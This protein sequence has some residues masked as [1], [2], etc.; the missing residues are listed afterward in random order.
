MA[1][2]KY[3]ATRLQARAVYA[4][5]AIAHQIDGDEP[6]ALLPQKDYRALGN[7]TQKPMLRAEGEFTYVAQMVH[8]NI[9]AH[10]AQP[11]MT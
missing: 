5:T 7:S 8:S 2:L 9:R 11:Q 4:T 3:M 1:V 10:G 6:I